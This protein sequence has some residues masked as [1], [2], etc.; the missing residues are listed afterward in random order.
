MTEPPRPPG[1][2]NP[3]DPTRPFN[4]PPPPPPYTPPPSYGPP[5]TSGAGG[6]GPPPGDPYG[7][8]PPYG[9][10]YGQQPYGQQ[11][12]YGGGYQQ[13][14]SPEDKNW[15]L[16][17]HFG[18]AAGAFIGGGCL[19]WVAPLIAML[20]RGTQ[21]PAVR[22][23]AV[24]ALNFQLLWSIVAVAGYILSCIG[25]GIL[26]A[27]GAMLF[28]TIIGIIA[29]VKASNNEPYRYPLTMSVIK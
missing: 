25:I 4:Q 1:E 27:L 28:A 8:Q 26:V 18:G 2:G 20:G 14:G 21:S 6:Y 15:I 29:G 10:P 23:Q 24:A 13:Q 3:E 9:Q 22:A 17:A 5:P 11:P 12:P 16:T 19:G 7:Q